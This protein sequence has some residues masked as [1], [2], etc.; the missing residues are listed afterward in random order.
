MGSEKCFGSKKLMSKNK[1][2]QQ[3]NV[4]NLPLKFHQY[5]V[6]TS[7]DIADIEL[8]WG[9]W[10]GWF[11]KSFSCQTQLRL[12]YIEVELSCGCVWSLTTIFN[13]VSVAFTFYIER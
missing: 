5:R 4:W 3:K 10:V 13:L 7:R 2:G 9:G 6:E 12:C 1:F 11:A 8:L